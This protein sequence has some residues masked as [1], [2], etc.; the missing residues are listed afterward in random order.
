LLDCITAAAG[1][2]LA[3]GRKGVAMALRAR[4]ETRYLANVLPLTA[5]ARRKAGIA[6]SAVATVF[7]QRA[8]LELRSPPE[9]LAKEFGL[10]PAEVRVLFAIVNVGV[11]SEVAEMLGISEATVRTHLHRLF[12]KTATARQAEL[13]KLVA[14]YT[15]PLLE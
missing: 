14:G 3:L 13:V 10:T 7:I 6:Y 8:A 15:N 2:D 12:E 4:D 1:G 11:V 5:G 9:A